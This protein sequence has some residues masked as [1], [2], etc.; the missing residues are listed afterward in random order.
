[1]TKKDI[2]RIVSVLR[3]VL[4]KLF[5]EKQEYLVGLAEGMEMARGLTGKEPEEKAS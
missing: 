5:R 3:E 2:Q 1:M 4:L